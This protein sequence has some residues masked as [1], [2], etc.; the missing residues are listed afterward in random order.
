M[1]L[2]YFDCFSGV[3][4]DMLIGALLDC[5][6]SFEGFHEQISSLNLPVNL[7]VHKRVVNGI[8]C[9]DFQV[10]PLNPAPLRHLHHIVEIIEKSGLSDFV[11]AGSL[12]VFHQLAAA[13]S[14]VHGISV[15]QVHFH[16]I[17]AVDTIV[18]VV[19]AF[20]CLELLGITTVYSSPLPWSSG[21]VDIS[22]GR[23][24][25]PAPA[26][27][28]LL[29][30][31]PCYGSDVAM[32]LVTPTGAALLKTLCSHF[33]TLPP[34]IP[35]KVG[36]GVG[37]KVRNDNVPNLLRVITA[38][39]VLPTA[40]SSAG[41]MVAVLEAEVDDLNP[42]VFSHLY[43]VLLED[44]DILDFFTS[45]VIMKKNRPGF[46]MTILASPNAASRICQIMIEQTATLGVR[47]R[48]ESR[49]IVERHQEII[50]TPWGEVRLKIWKLPS[51]GNRFKPE[52]DDCHAIAVKYNIPLVDVLTT[53][54]HL[55]SEKMLSANL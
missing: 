38:D 3:S 47:Y 49:L 20:V 54:N 27:A 7:T 16:E 48:L 53:L 29:Q 51:G 33:G 28:L 11:T 45:P 23:Y 22:H 14:K 42:E 44:K 18:D 34:S 43:N 4:G 10:I 21:Y 46:L 8:R 12:K 40:D 35:R 2:L 41:P 5:E 52:Y 26:T 15:D 13:E 9:C 31:I 50:N 1:S 25:V 6:V 24:P 36:Y 37:S 55:I 17:G 30:D 19:G 39:P 32:E